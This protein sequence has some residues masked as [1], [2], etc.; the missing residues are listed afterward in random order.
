MKNLKNTYKAINAKI[1]TLIKK[2]KEIFAALWNAEQIENDEKATKELTEDW[3]DVRVELKA[4]YKMLRKIA[5]MV[6]QGVS[7][8]GTIPKADPNKILPIK[9][10]KYCRYETLPTEVQDK[11][12]RIE[13]NDKYI[14]Y[15][16][17]GSVAATLKDAVAYLV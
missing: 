5:T 6:E 13:Y 9:G 10:W 1:E 16:K 14:Y 17:A 12:G 4:E 8:T 3:D 11:I 2:E 7:W 15:T